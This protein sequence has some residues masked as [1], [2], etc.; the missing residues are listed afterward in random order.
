M[1]KMFSLV[2]TKMKDDLTLF[3]FNFIWSVSLTPSTHQFKYE[4]SVT[5]CVCLHTNCQKTRHGVP[6]ELQNHKDAYSSGDVSTRTVA[7]VDEISSLWTH[8]NASTGGQWRGGTHTNWTHRLSLRCHPFLLGGLLRFYELMWRSWCVSRCFILPSHNCPLRRENL[9]WLS[10]LNR[11]SQCASALRW[12]V[13]MIH[14]INYFRSRLE[15]AVY[16]HLIAS[17]SPLLPPPLCCYL[18]DLGLLTGYL[19]SS[20]P[21]GRHLHV[22]T[23]RFTPA[24]QL[25]LW[26]TEKFWL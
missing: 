2:T 10:L 12:D 9:S 22:F 18:P 21:K 6:A 1:A 24:A 5:A 25:W 8:F 4:L 16:L 11:P 20:I 15:T 13:R 3:N 17:H 19:S 14:L 23:V 26:K 7:A